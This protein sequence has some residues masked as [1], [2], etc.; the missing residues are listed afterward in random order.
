MGD[1][2]LEL[3]YE[4]TAGG[5]VSAVGVNQLKERARALLLPLLFVAAATA[6]LLA[7]LLAGVVFLSVDRSSSS[8]VSDVS[9]ASDTVAADLLGE[10]W[11]PLAEELLTAMDSET[12]ACED[13]YR[14]ACGGWL[15][16]AEIAA[17]EVAIE[18]SFS[19]VVENNKALLL[20]IARDNWPL[21]GT[22]FDD[23]MDIEL[24]NAL[25]AAPLIPF[26]EELSQVTEENFASLL[27]QFNRIGIS[28]LFSIGV[29][30]DLYDPSR[31]V[32]ELD[33]GGY[34]L[35]RDYY[36]INDTSLEAYYVQH[37][38]N[39]LALVAD[40]PAPDDME[41]ALP[42][43]EQAGHVYQLEVA[44]ASAALP[45]A[46]RR[47]PA[48]MYHMLSVQALK[49][50]CPSFDWDSY[51]AAIGMPA[52]IQQ[53]N[54]I[55]P[56]FFQALESTI[57]TTDFE[58]LR[59]YLRWRLARSASGSLSQAF[60]DEAFSLT[61]EIYGV[62]VPA[63]QEEI[64]LSKVN[65][66]L[67][68]LVGRY[69]V[70]QAWSDSKQEAGEILLTSIKD[71]FRARL[72]TTEWMDETTRNGAYEKLDLMGDKI[73]S[74][75]AW[76]DYSELIL[77]P[78]QLLNNTFEGYKWEFDAMMAA[79]GQDVNRD[80]WLM[81]PQ[82]VNA[83]YDPAMNEMVFPAAIL[84]EP[85]FSDSFPEAVNYGGIGAVMGHELT[86]GFDDQGAQFDARGRYRSWWSEA[87]LAAFDERTDCVVDLYSGFEVQDGLY[88]NGDQTQGENIA[89]MG[90]VKDAFQAMLSQLQDVPEKAS[91][92]EDVFGMTNEQLFF[93][94]YGQVWCQRLTPAYEQYLAYYD[95]HSPGKARVNIP[96]S[97]FPAF[98]EAFQCPVGSTMNPN[99]RCE[100]W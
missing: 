99:E 88:L 33:Q 19:T 60:Y 20:S 51:L 86:H 95:V 13:F 42:L 53:A 17:D 12:D 28:A 10:L 9:D 73:G 72:E 21:V 4:E 15:D 98:A 2:V 93:V 94:S 36:F 24:R 6:V 84:Q 80:E 45:A 46:E 37:I 35:P 85:F 26:M 34:G 100:V 77:Y 55:V 5:E 91:I 66:L 43:L 63:P 89:D 29:E 39:T 31:Y 27:G 11:A 76:P 74:P 69:F 30:P 71:A 16:S 25:G 57:H 52:G 83:Y 40:L 75:D 8:D 70:Q 78:H 61:Q 38:A 23:C 50:L 7:L 97:Q 47:D 96:L 3:E 64:C 87:S 59:N 65:S 92:A 48:A 18:K 58:V 82:T 54:V 14:Y 49:E 41:T 32:F 62:E 68:M 44:L 79:V 22:L 81:S 67:G 90:G 56:S 1:D